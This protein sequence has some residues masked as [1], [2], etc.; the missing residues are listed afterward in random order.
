ME[1]R[2][3]GEAGTKEEERMKEGRQKG[4]KGGEG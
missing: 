1:G 2:V 3:K 4:P